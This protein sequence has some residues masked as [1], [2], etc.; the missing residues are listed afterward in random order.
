MTKLKIL[1]LLVVVFGLLFRVET[2]YAMNLEIGCSVGVGLI[3][4]PDWWL[5]MQSPITTSLNLGLS[6][7]SNYTLEGGFTRIWNRQ[8]WWNINPYIWS[9]SIIGNTEKAINPR[10]G[11]D[12]Y[13]GYKSRYG[14]NFGVRFV[15]SPA[16]KFSYNILALLRFEDVYSGPGFEMSLKPRGLFV[17]FGVHYKW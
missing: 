15:P 16:K 7:C 13:T 8:E 3:S 6:F 9:I 1:I 10:L 14:W 4:V 2:V 11:I 17:S 12:Y 5:N